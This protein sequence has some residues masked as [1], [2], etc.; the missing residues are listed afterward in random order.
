MPCLT[1]QAQRSRIDDKL[2]LKGK[3]VV[4]SSKQGKSSAQR[5]Q[6][7][8][9]GVQNAW[10]ESLLLQNLSQGIQGL[11]QTRKACPKTTSAAKE[12]EPVAELGAY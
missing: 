5:F 7:L 12:E 11:S 3:Q 4:C 10:R 9:A 8:V 2:C 6:D 1:L